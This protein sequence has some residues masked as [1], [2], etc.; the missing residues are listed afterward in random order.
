MVPLTLVPVHDW[1][2]EA[3]FDRLE[4]ALR[5]GRIQERTARPMPLSAAI[6]FRVMRAVRSRKKRARSAIAAA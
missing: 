3:I 4:E 6:P 1:A 5:T 2:V